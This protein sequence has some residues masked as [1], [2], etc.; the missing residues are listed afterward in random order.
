[1]NSAVPEGWSKENIGSIFEKISN[2]T[3]ANQIETE[4]GES[5]TRI[6]TISDGYINFEKVG[7]ID[8]SDAEKRYLMKQGDILFSNINSVKHIGKVAFFNGE[9][10]L[11]HGM[12]LLL[13]RANEGGL[14]SV[15]AFIKLIKLR[16][17][18]LRALQGRKPF[19]RCRLD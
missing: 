11:F 8:I 18:A 4:N 14:W 13:F 5:V 6:E 15:R 7:K 12:N 16:Q 17:G 2:G 10:P 1:M 9:K 3:T 19:R